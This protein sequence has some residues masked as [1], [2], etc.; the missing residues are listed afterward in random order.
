MQWFLA[1]EDPLSKALATKLL[2]H[3]FGN[4][5]IAA[6]LGQRGNSQMFMDMRDNKYCRLAKQHPILVLTDLDQNSCAPTLKERWCNGLALPAKL[7]FRIVVREAEAWLLADAEGFS[8]VSGIGKGKL[9]R[10]V[11]TLNSPKEQMLSLVRKYGNRSIKEIL[12]NLRS[13]S[14][15][16]PSYNNILVEC[17]KNNWDPKR[18]SARSLSLKK[19]IDRLNEFQET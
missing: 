11:E 5:E 12:P 13:A 7:F 17:V 8:S 14:K 16:S 9:P 4:I 3:C 15:V 18:G 1:T 6:D 10:D 2:S 19:A